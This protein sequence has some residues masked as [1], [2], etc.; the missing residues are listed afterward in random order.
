[1]RSSL[2]FRLAASI[3]VRSSVYTAI[4]FEKRGA[5]V[6]YAVYQDGSN[7]GIRAVDITTGKDRRISSRSR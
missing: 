4:R 2:G 5:D 6:W 3:A 7:N 1:M